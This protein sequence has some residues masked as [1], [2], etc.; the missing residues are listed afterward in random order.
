[1]MQG[2]ILAGLRGSGVQEP[3]VELIRFTSED[4]TFLVQWRQD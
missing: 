4:A 3:R 1:L 2:A